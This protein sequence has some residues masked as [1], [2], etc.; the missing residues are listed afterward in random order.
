MSILLGKINA[1]KENKIWLFPRMS[2]TLD[3]WQ[4]N[5]T[6]HKPLSYVET[7]IAPD[8]SDRTEAK[9]ALPHCQYTLPANTL[10]QKSSV[11][12]ILGNYLEF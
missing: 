11:G 2:P 3:F 9:G 1:S 10:C 5:F 8:V 4:N 7:R 12:D 6:L